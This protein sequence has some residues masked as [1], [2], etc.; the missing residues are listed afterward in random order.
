MRNGWTAFGIL[1]ALIAPVAAGAQVCGDANRTGSVTVTDGVLV[2]RAA[3]D[4]PSNCSRDLCDMNLDG[5]VSVTDGVLAL[6]LAAG[7]DA[8]VVC[9]ASEAGAIF[10]QLTKSLNFGVGAGAA[11]RTRAAATTPCSGGGFTSDDG[12]VLTFVDCREGDVVTNGTLAFAPNGSDAVDVGFAT[13]DRYL[14]T[15]EIVDTDGTLTFT[16]GDDVQV[17][18]F[19]ALDSNQ[20]GTYEEELSAV[21]LD[22]EFSVF[23]GQIEIA[24]TEGRDVFA[25]LSTI[26]V[27]IYSPTLVRFDVTYAD[28]SFDLFTLADG[29]C[30]PCSGG[31]GNQSLTCVSCVDGCTGDTGRCGIDFNFVGCVDGIFGPTGLCEPCNSDLDCNASEGLG[32][33]EC[34][35]NCTGNGGRCGSSKAFV[36]CEDGTF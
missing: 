22:Q 5:D 16:F 21:L 11:G 7:I 31:C 15:G 24:I 30:E 3:A 10:G 25:N 6:Q 19:L 32:C 33:F 13:T 4:L 34:A 20:F 23:S 26:L 9:S 2:L 29:L 27:T 14:A 17:D 8:Q 35:F 1:V 36:E 12:S 28:G 18:G